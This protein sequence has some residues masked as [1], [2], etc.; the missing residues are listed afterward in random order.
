MPSQRNHPT[1]SKVLIRSILRQVTGNAVKQSRLFV[2][3][4]LDCRV[5]PLLANV[6]GKVHVEEKQYER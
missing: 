6:G 2:R 4:P 1:K 3:K 5:A